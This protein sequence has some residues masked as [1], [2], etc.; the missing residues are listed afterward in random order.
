MESVLHVWSWRLPPLRVWW[1]NWCEWWLLEWLLLA[2][3][4]RDILTPPFLHDWNR[5]ITKPITTV[6]KNKAVPTPARIVKAVAW[7]PDGRRPL[8]DISLFPSCTCS[9]FASG[10]LDKG[11]KSPPPFSTWVPSAIKKL[12]IVRF[13][14]NRNIAEINQLQFASN[15]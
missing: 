12:K 14:L 9:C 5:I 6:T 7:F 15:I 13:Y 10:I 3:L 4:C 8:F 1:P 11:F 2:L